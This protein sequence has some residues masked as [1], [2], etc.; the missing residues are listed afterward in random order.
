M[1]HFT[2]PIA[3][4]PPCWLHHY[5]IVGCCVYFLQP[6]RFGWYS[7]NTHATQSVHTRAS[8]API[9]AQTNETRFTFH[10]KSQEYKKPAARRILSEPMEVSNHDA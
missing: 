9:H 7:L 5:V 2:L 6:Q 1:F 8:Y 4:L 10:T 3:P